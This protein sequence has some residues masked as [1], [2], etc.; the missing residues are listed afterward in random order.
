MK[1]LI[2]SLLVLIMCT[3][4]ISQDGVNKDDFKN[5]GKL[6]YP[7]YDNYFVV[8]HAFGGIDGYDYTNTYE[9]LVENYNKGTRVFEIDLSHTSDGELVLLHEWKQ[10]HEV[11]GLGENEG[12]KKE[13]S[14]YFLNTKIYDNYST[15]TF[16]YLLKIMNRVP[17]FYIVIDSK[18]FTVD[19]TKEMYD[20]IVSRVNS[21]N[22]KLIKR[23]IPQAY[24]EDIY[25]V[26]TEYDFPDVILTLYAMY[27]DSDGEKI[28]NIV[29]SR[30]IK[31][32]VM[33]MD[34]SW[35]VRVIEDVR[36]YASYSTTWTND[37]FNIYIHTINDFDKVDYIVYEEGFSGI[38]SDFI[39][40]T[41]YLEHFR[42]NNQ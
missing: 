32:V 30:K 38:Y 15:M 14:E 37:D 24:S 3:A 13:S 34:D 11:F 20:E 8:A 33:H 21:V 18:T 36:D 4:C 7:W 2:T 28:Y 10:Y 23:I 27:A 41:E 5:Q 1:K 29:E 35:A 25:D 17:D 9:A 16:D 22:S 6:K 40:E 31:N 19:E 39:S 12:W 26:L 42:N